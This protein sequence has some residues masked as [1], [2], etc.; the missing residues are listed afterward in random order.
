[1][2]GESERVGADCRGRVAC[3]S[4]S[5]ENSIRARSSGG[6]RSKKPERGAR[7]N[8]FAAERRDLIAVTKRES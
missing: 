8:L 1:M 3:A 2:P 5:V 6:P 7:A 4:V